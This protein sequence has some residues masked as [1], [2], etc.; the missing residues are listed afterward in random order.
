LV[1][2]LNGRLGED[3]GT[4]REAVLLQTLDQPEP[5]DDLVVRFAGYAD[6]VGFLHDLTELLRL[7]MCSIP[8]LD[9]LIAEDAQCAY[10]PLQF[11]LELG[12]L[13][14]EHL[15]SSD[16]D[17]GAQLGHDEREC[18]AVAPADA[19]G[20]GEVVLGKIQLATTYESRAGSNAGAGERNSQVRA[21]VADVARRHLH[22]KL[23][24][25][26]IKLHAPLGTLEK[27]VT[28]G[29]DTERNDRRVA[30]VIGRGE[31]HMQAHDTDVRFHFGRVL[32]HEVRVAMSF[33]QLLERRGD[34]TGVVC[35]AG[36]THVLLVPSFRDRVQLRG[37]SGSHEHVQV[38]ARGEEGHTFEDCAGKFGVAVDDTLL[39]TDAVVLVLYHIC[40]GQCNKCAAGSVEGDLGRHMRCTLW[41]RYGK[42]RV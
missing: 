32:E 23:P 17:R 4:G 24:Q 3:E 22:V 40:V 25:Y 36:I 10:H 42:Q 28:V 34:R 15:H 19:A 39:G 5:Q 11:R 35:E 1:D 7:A 12:H 41:V 20:G 37:V 26:Q 29:E 31:L 8:G 38:P 6:V 9:I 27:H 13:H 14:G 21:A 33:A 30:A 18:L 16:E 2:F